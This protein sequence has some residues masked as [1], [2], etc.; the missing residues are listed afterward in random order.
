MYKNIL[1][2]LLC[3]FMPSLYGEE[4]L[5][6][7]TVAPYVDMVQ[8]LVDKEVTVQLVVPTGYSSHTFEPT[9]RQM[10]RASHAQIWFIIGELFETKA[11]KA[12]QA[13]NPKLRVVDLRQGLS[14][15]SDH[16]C[17]AHSHA[18]DLHIWMSPKMI[19]TQ[20][21]LMAKSL[22]ETF[23]ELKEKIERNL[24]TLLTKLEELD[25]FIRNTLKDAVGK[26][27]FV[28]HPAYGYFCREFGLQQV[29][30][31]FEGKD[32]TP[33]QIV[34]IVERARKDK[35]THI[36]VQEQYSRKASQIIANEIGAEIVV[37]D[38]YAENYFPNMQQIATSFARSMMHAKK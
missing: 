4:R 22:E 14:L 11:I 32:P 13:Q 25:T 5:V 38:P 12:L 21:R 1:L 6:L 33:R 24:K 37:L 16:T 35:I 30:I 34:Q 31:E 15:L 7:V 10:L 36:F 17:K 29:S 26:T 2:F 18:A 23:P 28:S 9:P 19:E 8:A 20:V 27:I 3:F